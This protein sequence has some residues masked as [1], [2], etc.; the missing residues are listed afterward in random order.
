MDGQF[1][2]LTQNA[3]LIATVLH[4]SGDRAVGV[5]EFKGKGVTLTSTARAGTVGCTVSATT[6]LVGCQFVGVPQP[7]RVQAQVAAAGFADVPEGAAGPWGEQEGA[8][9]SWAD[10][11]LVVMIGEAPEGAIVE[12]TLE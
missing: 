3:S 1:L 7:S 2:G 10:G 5:R 11:S 6:R 12:A 9:W 8:M 4:P